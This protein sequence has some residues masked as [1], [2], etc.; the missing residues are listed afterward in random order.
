MTRLLDNSVHHNVFY[1]SSKAMRTS[2]LHSQHH[3]GLLST[4]EACI[5][6]QE[7]QTLPHLSHI[8][9]SSSSCP[10]LFLAS[11]PLPTRLSSLIPITGRGRSQHKVSHQKRRSNTMILCRRQARELASPNPSGTR[12]SSP[13][14]ST[15]SK[16]LA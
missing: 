4:E 9:R 12:S 5:L 13:F 8:T 1:F 2:L 3:K 7:P 11:F 16:K 6:S 14:P 15:Y 10:R